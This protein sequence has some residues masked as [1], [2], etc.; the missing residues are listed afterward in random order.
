MRGFQDT[1]GNS[2]AA[3]QMSV[4]GGA[5]ACGM[6]TRSSRR[7]T[8]RAPQQPP[9]RAPSY[10]GGSDGPS[11]PNGGPLHRKPVDT[12]DMGGDGA[13]SARRPAAAAARQETGP[14]L[15]SYDTLNSP[16]L[17]LH[18]PFTLRCAAVRCAL[19]MN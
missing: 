13:T 1:G 15:A 4:D 16:F 17:E 12:G 10:G 14:D 3:A 6:T 18:A 7:G 5:E 19:E 9:Q 2:A 8:G 11:A